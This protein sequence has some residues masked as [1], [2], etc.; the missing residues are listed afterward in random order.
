MIMKS[1]SLVLFESAIKSPE[2]R[3][4]YSYS[5]REFKKFAKI[6]DC[7]QIVK[8]DTEKIQKI[9]E[10]WVMHLT[11]KGLKSNTIRAKLCAIELFLDM[12]K[13]PFHKKILHKLIPSSDY[14]P[15]G[16]IPFTTED[17]Q[18]FLDSTTKLRTKALVHFLASTGGRPA[19]ITDPVLRLK[20]IEDMPYGCKSIKIYDGSKEGYFAFLTPEAAKALDHYHDSRKRNGE[21]LDS[22]SPVFVNYDKPNPAKKNDYLSAKS[23]GVIMQNLIKT[24][25]IERTK[26]GNRFDKATT[27]GFR[28]RFNTILK[29]NNDVNS[30]IAEKL[31]A[32]KNGLDGSYLKPTKEECFAEF[33]KAVSNL[34]V[35]DESRNKLKIKK[36]EQE[37]SAIERLESEVK[38]LR[39]WVD[40][41]LDRRI[42]LE[43][44]LVTGLVP[45]EL[46]DIPR[47]GHLRLQQKV[48]KDPA[49]YGYLRHLFPKRYP[50]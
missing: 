45:F 33:L 22:E 42:A 26:Q 7:D 50:A 18:R 24:S 3:K 2:S 32:H 27:Y 4:S 28:K 14:V 39:E 37:K 36:L 31:M 40:P 21:S 43:S 9:L 17:I 11:D 10:D 19:G 44:D 13:K 20:H 1:R 38:K 47:Y 12:N 5:F 49:T 25:G 41:T 16:E 8:L 23:V 15:G 35:S 46:P 30:N 34:T 29:L 48:M 6:H